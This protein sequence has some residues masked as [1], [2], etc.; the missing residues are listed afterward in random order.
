MDDNPYSA[1][2]DDNLPSNVLKRFGRA[3]AGYPGLLV[4]W[5]SEMGCS[6]HSGGASQSLSPQWQHM[7]CVSWCPLRPNIR[8]FPHPDLL[9]IMLPGSIITV[10]SFGTFWLVSVRASLSAAFL[11]KQDV[12]AL[13][14]YY[15]EQD[16]SVSGERI[17]FGST[18]LLT[19]LLL[20]TLVG[21]SVPKCGEAYKAVG[22]R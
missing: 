20:M 3:T 22:G 2:V 21:E 17:G 9:T 14:L 7:V 18:M 1:Q 4:R 15:Y 12:H 6:T 16:V 13:W 5:A 19:I 10:L 8:A 11:R